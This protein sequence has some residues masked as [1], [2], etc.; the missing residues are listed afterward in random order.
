MNK[1]SANESSY[2]ILG[3]TRDATVED[4]KKAYR[5]KA[6]KLHPDR[7][8]DKREEATRNMATLNAA[9]EDISRANEE[10]ILYKRTVSDEIRALY[11]RTLKD[12]SAALG[13]KH[14]A[15]L[16]LPKTDCY[17]DVSIENI[18]KGCVLQ[19][20][21]SHTLFVANWGDR[22]LEAI[23]DLTVDAGQLP[24][25]VLKFTRVAG[26]MEI[27]DALV[28]RL[29]AIPHPKYEI[30][31]GLLHY[32]HFSE[33]VCALI[34]K[35]ITVP[36][37][38]ATEIDVRVSLTTLTSRRMCVEGAGLPTAEGRSD[39]VIVFKSDATEK[40]PEKPKEREIHAVKKKKHQSI[41]KQ[42]RL[43]RDKIKE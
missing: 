33:N 22:V 36:L 10:L 20:K 1:P 18:Y 38:D 35:N 12:K 5:T 42:S 43:K 24:D 37:P 7:N 30:R 41:F 31:N 17:I 27:T 29:R 13:M 6:I 28:P 25:S 23:L 9:F 3:L 11:A 19:R 2:A 8:P 15:A 40:K 16:V 14:G 4:I 21:I 32:I 26:A 39:L 34:T